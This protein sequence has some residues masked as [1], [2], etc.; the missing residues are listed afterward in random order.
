MLTMTRGAKNVSAGTVTR[1]LEAVNELSAL[2]IRPEELRLGESLLGGEDKRL[3]SKLSDLSLIYSL[4]KTKLSERYADITEDVL[5]LAKKLTD[6]PGYLDNTVIFIEGFTSFTE[7]QYALIKA[8]ARRADISISLTVRKAAKD[9]FEY[10]EIRETERRLVKMARD[11]GGD[12]KLLTPDALKEGHEP[13][14]TEIADLL[15]RNEGEIDNDSLQILQNN[16]D[17]IRIFEAAT[18]FEECDFIA[19]DIKRRVIGGEKYNDF[20]IIA[21]G[22]LK[23]F[24]KKQ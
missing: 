16:E 1:A 17:V 20:A 19:A 23:Q 10:K 22:I 8:M 24:S 12:I 2:G 15:W 6:N 5:G 11:E 14:L 13:V 7:P 21:R 18:P 9:S 4:Y 3:K